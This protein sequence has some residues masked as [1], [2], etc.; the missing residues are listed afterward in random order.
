MM[1]LKRKLQRLL[2]Q[3]SDASIIQTHRVPSLDHI[4]HGQEVSTFGACYMMEKAP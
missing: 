1:D 2:P 3:P 4:L